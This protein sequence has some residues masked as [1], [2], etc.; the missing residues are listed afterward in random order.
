MH[1][2]AGLRF[3]E[4]RLAEKKVQLD[5]LDKKILTELCKNARLSQSAI[6]KHV[7]TSRDTVNYRITKL[8]DAGVLQGYR[9]I[10]DISK[11]G[12]LNVHL[13]LQLNQPSKEAM[14]SLVQKLKSY[15][16]LRSIIQCNGKYDLELAIAAKD[17]HDCDQ[18]IAKIC[19]DCNDM[20][21]SYDIVFVT[22]S[23]CANCFPKSFYEVALSSPVFSDKPLQP[24]K[25]DILLLELLAASGD[26]PVYKLAEHLGLSS[27]AVT[28][29]IKKLHKAGY[30]IG[31][32]PA[33]NY[34]L[35][36]Y[37][38]YAVLVSVTNL[39]VKD[40]A[41]LQQFLQTNKD[42]L[43]AVKA[44]GR[45]SLIVYIATQQMD[46]FIR[47]ADELRNYLVGKIKDYQMLINIESH[48]YIYLPKGLLESG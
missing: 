39:T 5:M 45:Y 19:N 40:E 16:F 41:T 32:V 21:Q 29:R 23:L 6:A 20:L 35:I 26:L 43:W 28:Y 48:K 42:V 38:V 2:G 47:T 9:A 8:K 12:Y 24:D 4:T 13:F 1:G 22:K 27:D 14:G 17:V 25:K 31:Y 11:F 37:S 3:T 10:V 36:D 33:V 34:H 18:I 46:N 15:P 7:K 30:I 44:M